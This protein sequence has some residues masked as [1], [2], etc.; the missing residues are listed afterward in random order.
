MVLHKDVIYIAPSQKYVMI[1]NDIFALTDRTGRTNQTADT[2]MLSLAA[3][4]HHRSIG[5]V[6]EG[7]LNDGTRGLQGIR[8]A[9][10]FTIAQDPATCLF[11]GMPLNA[12]DAGVVDRI[13][14]ITDMPAIIH[15][16]VRLNSSP[17][18]HSPIRH[19]PGIL[20]SRSRRR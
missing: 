2:F 8:E 5:I 9:G 20:P 18:I 1:H 10:G 15:E 6:T 17:P 13:A 11:N 3:N 14:T 16:Y 7:T 19:S 4:S 12:I